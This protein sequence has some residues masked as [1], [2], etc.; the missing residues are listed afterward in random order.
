MVLLFPK[1]VPEKLE[2]GLKGLIVLQ[3]IS[4]IKVKDEDDPLRDMRALQLVIV[5]VE[6]EVDFRKMNQNIIKTSEET[7]SFIFP[8]SFVFDFSIF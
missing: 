8:V 6:E 4:F 7:L 3:S 5:V 2:I 1:N